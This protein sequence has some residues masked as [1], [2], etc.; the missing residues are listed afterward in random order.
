MITAKNIRSVTYT[1]AA[2]VVL[3]IAALVGG[4][5]SAHDTAYSSALTQLHEHVTSGAALSRLFSSN[6]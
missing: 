3:A 1:V 2:L 5:A 6:A 4:Q